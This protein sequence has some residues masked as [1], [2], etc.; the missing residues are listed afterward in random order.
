MKIAISGSNGLIGTI[1]KPFLENEGN[2]VTSIVRNP[3]Q[4]G[5]LWNP[6]NEDISL[7]LLEGF[8][9]II[10]LNG[11]KIDSILP[12]SD[13]TGIKNSRISSTKT[14]SVA[15]SKLNYPPKIF[16]SASGFGYYGDRGEQNLT[17]EEYAGKGF[18]SQLALEWENSATAY[19]SK[20]IETRVILLRFGLV[21]SNNGGLLPILKGLTNLQIGKM[22]G[23]GKQFWPWISIEDTISAIYHVINNPVLRGAVN[24]VS[25]H[26][27][28]NKEFMRI[29][30]KAINKKVFIPIPKFLIS[31]LTSESTRN[32]LL[33]ST[34]MYP[35]KLLSSN[36]EFNFES[37]DETLEQIFKN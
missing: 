31:S 23:D 25:P 37:L 13:K 4:N 36:F 19:I 1:L 12:I 6:E 14:L 17:E 10:N 28:T 22:F 9:C 34:K 21:L 8:D 33:N 18:L 24:F 7:E 30:L 3:N 20:D 5:I 2:Q 29:Y 15:I 26:Q 11:K 27:T 32:T 35:E 16:I